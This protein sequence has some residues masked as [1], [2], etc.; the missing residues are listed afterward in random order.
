MNR[1]VYHL[2]YSPSTLFKQKLLFFWKEK[3]CGYELKYL[4]QC[5]IY[6]LCSY[7]YPGNFCGFIFLFSISTVV[8][9]NAPINVKPHSPG[10]G[11]VGL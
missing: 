3:G 1:T 2:M 10:T 7:V 11:D 5:I 9:S 8:H 4:K 6:Y